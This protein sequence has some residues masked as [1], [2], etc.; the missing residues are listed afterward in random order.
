V[1]KEDVE[2][3]G[4]VFGQ[5]PIGTGPF[6]LASWEAKKV[7]RLQAFASFYKGAPYL[8]EVQ[9]FIY[10]GSNIQEVL[11]DFQDGK[12]EEMPM[13]WQFREK[14]IENK[15][16]RW[17]HRPSLSLLFYG[18]NCQH[19]L[20]QNLELRRALGAAIDR[21]RIVSEVYKGQFEPAATLLPP[22]MLGYQ[23]LSK[24][25]SSDSGKLAES[26]V[27]KAPGGSDSLLTL[28]VVSNS[29]STL[30][31]AELDLV[32][33]AWGQLG[34]NMVPKFIPDWS[35]FEQYLQSDSLQIYRYA[36]F[37]DIPDPD[38]FLQPLFASASKV[39]YMRFRNDGIDTVL[40]RARGVADPIERANLYRQMEEAVAASYPLVPLFYLSVDR[41]YQPYTRGIEMSALGEPY[42]SYHRVWLDAPS[43][44]K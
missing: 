17:L 38:N 3:S 35:Q 41:I 2:R 31:K 33:E 10:P 34:I 6:Q 22:G 12:L 43:E 21:Q 18:F 32:R 13:Y 19:P 36:W 4:T 14:L 9:Y 1:P 24:L 27:K 11:S 39:N 7:I 29:Q 37:A 5:K 16:L 30:A 44:Q 40:R 26:P 25:W 42:I 8:Q 23:P 20:L 15:K 28:E